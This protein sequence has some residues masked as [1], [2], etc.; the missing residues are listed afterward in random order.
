ML[1]YLGIKIISEASWPA[2]FWHLVLLRPIS[3]DITRIKQ[4]S[5]KLFHFFLSDRLDLLQWPERTEG[6]F[7]FSIKVPIK[8][9][10]LC[11][12][13]YLHIKLILPDYTFIIHLVK[14]IYFRKRWESVFTHQKI[15]IVNYKIRFSVS[16]PSSSV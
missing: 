14:I 9:L 10:N 7:R 15:H 1:L 6:S 11:F 8:F 13:F 12:H 2:A 16:F 3:L 4:V 5:P